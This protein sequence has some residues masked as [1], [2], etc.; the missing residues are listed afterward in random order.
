MF[1]GYY[2]PFQLIIF[3]S[4]PANEVWFILVLASLWTGAAIATLTVVTQNAQ[5]LI[6][7]YDWSGGIVA[8]IVCLWI[9]AGIALVYW[10]G[11][12]LYLYSPTTPLEYRNTSVYEARASV[13]PN[14]IVKAEAD[15]GSHHREMQFGR[16]SSVASERSPSP[17][18][19]PTGLQ[20]ALE[21]VSRHSQYLDSQQRE[22]LAARLGASRHARP[23]GLDDAFSVLMEHAED[24]K[25]QEVQSVLSSLGQSSRQTRQDLV[26]P[27]PLAISPAP[28]Y[29]SSPAG[30]A[31]PPM[32]QIPPP[33]SPAPT[34]QTH[35]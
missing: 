13:R 7:D 8:Q 33:S 18:E 25:D 6:S 11:S 30:F 31:R 34:Y 23:V 2:C 15:A 10:V 19:A 9:G 20:D 1:I 28:T 5:L 17:N 14:D 29:S 26:H 24:L 12:T 3:V 35:Y 22:L 27:I 32:L 4:R 16:T 21:L